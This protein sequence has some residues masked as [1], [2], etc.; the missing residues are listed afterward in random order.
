MLVIGIPLR[1]LLLVGSLCTAVFILRRIRQAKVQI[2]DSIFWLFFSAFL[3]LLSIFPE[4]ASWA[5]RMLQF[6]A[7]INLV[8]LLIIF[9]LLVHQFSMMVRISQLDFKLRTLAQ[10][11]ALNER[12]HEEHLH[13]EPKGE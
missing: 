8:Y 6:E 3:L 13:D 5:A 1:V 11:V 12:T 10:K 4:L 7:P 9:V 2:E